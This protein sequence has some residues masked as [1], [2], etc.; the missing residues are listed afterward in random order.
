MTHIKSNET[1]CKCCRKKEGQD[2][3]L[4]GIQTGFR[5]EREQEAGTTCLG[6]DDAGKRT[7]GRPPRAPSEVLELALL[8]IEASPTAGTRVLGAHRSR[9]GSPGKASWTHVKWRRL[10]LVLSEWLY[11]EVVRNEVIQ[12]RCSP[13]RK[14]LKNSAEGASKIHPLLDSKSSAD[15]SSPVYRCSLKC[16][17]S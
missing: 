4:I 15:E 13:V 5:E 14:A 17:P 12:G 3:E 16:S 10:V 11:Q 9:R 7:P 1:A 8:L 2:P 6:K